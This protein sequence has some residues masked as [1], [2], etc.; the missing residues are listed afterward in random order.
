MNGQ[1][2]GPTI[3]RK[4]DLRFRVGGRLNVCVRNAT[5]HETR[6]C[7]ILFQLSREIPKAASPPA[8]LAVIFIAAT[9]KKSRLSTCKT[10]RL[11]L[12]HVAVAEFRSRIFD[13]PRLSGTRSITNSELRSVRL[14]LGEH[15]PS[16]VRQK[17]FDISVVYA[18]VWE[19]DER[20]DSGN[21]DK[22]GT[23]RQSTS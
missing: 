10:F 14:A 17:L 5:R 13:P 19:S 2:G 22:I 9:I 7:R 8:D 23:P 3:D 15:F 21:S 6:R 20:T 18:V 12:M 11:G 1:T 16:I 4:R